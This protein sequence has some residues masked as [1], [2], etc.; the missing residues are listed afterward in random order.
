MKPINRPSKQRRGHGIDRRSALAGLAALALQGA[1]GPTIAQSSARRVVV[2][3]A[4]L[5]G[6]AAAR[7]LAR[8][9]HA[10]TVLEARNRIGGR[11]HTTRPWSDLPV[12]LGAGWIHGRGQNPILGLVRDAGQTP[13]AF[14]GEARVI[15]PGQPDGDWDDTAGPR[16]LGRA[17]SEA[18]AYAQDMSVMEALLI[19]DAWRVASDH[20]RHLALR[21]LRIE[22]EPSFGGTASALSAW[23]GLDGAQFPGPD[24]WVSGG[25]DRVTARLAQGL[26]IRLGQAVA[27]VSPGLVTLADGA[28][29]KADRILCTVP[30]GVLKS[31]RIAFDP[32]LDPALRAAVD[33]LDMGR[34]EK[35][36]L[37]FDTVAWPREADWI[38]AGDA[39]PF[40]AWAS[41]AR[42]GGA[43]VMAGFSIGDHATR[44]AALPA[45]D[46]LA[47][48]GDALRELFGSHFPNPSEARTTSWSTDPFAQGSYSFNAVGHGPRERRAMARPQWDGAL[49]FA[50]EAASVAHYGTMHGA[51]MAGRQAAKAM[52]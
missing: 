30:L 23:Y 5:S 25:L 38:A 14:D 11:V 44:I 34:V 41:C 20:V 19:S 46:A 4:G 1:A 36:W 37:R 43:P 31:G 49:W 7:Q 3:G 2:I 8:A 35:T 26:D 9:G 51:V 29:L 17:L 21:H 50:G 16:L 18:E 47:L 42:L 45:R 10:V 15:V 28:R 40:A 22:V 27:A 12:E 24:L 39:G 13:L 33:G 48:A 32:P 6:L 52:G